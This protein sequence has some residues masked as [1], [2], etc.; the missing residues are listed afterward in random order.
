M[1]VIILPT[2]AQLLLLLLLLLLYYYYNC[3]FV[4]RMIT[5]KKFN[6]K[7]F[8]LNFTF[9]SHSHIYT[10]LTPNLVHK[11]TRQHTLSLVILLLA[12]MVK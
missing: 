8:S 7:I 3:A 12:A 5:N 11:R 10:M 9:F 6:Q 1:I 4:G 2:N